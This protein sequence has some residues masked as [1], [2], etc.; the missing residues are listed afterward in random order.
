MNPFYNVKQHSNQIVNTPV[1]KKNSTVLDRS[2]EYDSIWK[3][4]L[5][6]PRIETSLIKKSRIDE[7]PIYAITS[8][9][10]KEKV[11]QAKEEEEHLKLEKELA[12]KAKEEEKNEKKRVQEEVKEKLKKLKQEEKEKKNE[13]QKQEK[14][15]KQKEKEELRLQKQKIKEEEIKKKKEIQLEKMQGKRN[16]KRTK[17]ERNFKEKS[18]GC[19]A[20]GSR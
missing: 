17:N 19:F 12:K 11:R 1:A 13:L 4:H 18:L 14:E 16:M 8:W 3:E 2:K 15:K 10:W 20:L 5:H 9:Q 6:F 7:A